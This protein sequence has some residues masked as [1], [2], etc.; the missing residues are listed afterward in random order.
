MIQGNK[1]RETEISKRNGKYASAD[2]GIIRNLGESEIE[3]IAQDGTKVKLV[4]QV[5]DKLTSM[6]IAVR[7]AVEN[8]NMV[9]FGANMKA[10]RKLAACEK[11]EPNMIVGKNGKRS[12]IVDQDGMYV[13]KLKVKKKKRD[14]MDI[15]NVTNEEVQC[16]TCGDDME[17]PF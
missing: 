6:L 2:G 1:I 5:G 12:E 3:G 7:R 15:G 17:D 11:V 13:Y 14:D 4:T 10:I 9:I 8:G 16:G